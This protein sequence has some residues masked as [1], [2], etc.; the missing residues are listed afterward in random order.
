[1]DESDVTMIDDKMAS[2]SAGWR[3]HIGRLL[4]GSIK[5]FLIRCYWSGKQLAEDCQEYSAEIVGH[6]PSHAFRLWWFRH[7]CRMR[8]GRHSS[9]HRRC[10]M[11]APWRITIGN[12]SVINC[13]VLLDGRRGLKIGD[14]VNISEGVVTLTLQHDID[15]PDFALEGG[16]IEV[17]EYVFVGAYARI[18]PGVSIGRGAVVA[19]GAVATRDV[20][21]YA[22][23]GGV[24]AHF[25]RERSHDLSYSSEWRKRLG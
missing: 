6:V 23:V 18:L 19:A 10:R 5:R 7:I 12:H 22:V 20:A 13:G 16:P 9:I 17:D 3:R 25:I 11:Q 2:A 14:N 15:A 4:P 21:P 24:P 1:M 8:I